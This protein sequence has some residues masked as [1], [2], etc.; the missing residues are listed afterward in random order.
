MPEIR[1]RSISE[2]I[3]DEVDVKNKFLQRNLA[4][5]KREIVASRG[6]IAESREERNVRI[7]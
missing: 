6:E 7:I 1:P 5:V 2:A 3:E 4:I